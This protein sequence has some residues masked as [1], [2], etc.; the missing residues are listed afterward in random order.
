MKEYKTNYKNWI[1]WYDLFYEII[2]PDDLLFYQSY[3]TNKTKDVLEMGIGTGRVFQTFI[4]KKINWTG[5]DD[6]EEMINLC[7][8][9][10]EP[11]QPLIGKLKLIN[12]DMTKLDIKENEKSIYNSKFDLVI[13]P[14]NSIMSVG[15]ITL[16]KDALCSGIKH[17]KD[18]GLI[19]FDLHNPNNYQIN[20]DFKLIAS[21]EIK[22][23]SYE[24]FGRSEI[25]LSIN[26][27]KNFKKIFID[28]KEI[29]ELISY[30]HFLYMDEVINLCLDL[31]LEI[32]EVYGGYNKE[33]VSDN[34]EE[35]I[36]I[37]KKK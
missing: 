17:L 19:I 1:I 25:D 8:E 5:I 28:S 10:I 35:L 7:K 4:N 22:K 11:E 20:K 29:I 16:Q 18:D 21:S 6:S 27:H 15:N 13:Y 33:K 37:C 30:D 12:D 3:I 32:T 2:K 14:S 36:Y 26:L 23:L 9:K 34:S 24:I 31:D